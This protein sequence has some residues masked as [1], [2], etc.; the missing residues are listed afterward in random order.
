MNT[1]YDSQAAAAADRVAAAA[2]TELL[3]TECA[4]RIGGSGYH[5]VVV[6]APAGAGKSYFIGSVIDAITQNSRRGPIAAIGTPTNAQAQTLVATLARRLPT[7]DFAYVPKKGLS[8]P[9]A[10][11]TLG[12]VH[13][14][15]AADAHAYPVTI[16]TLD[17]LGDANSRGNLQR[18]RYLLIDEAYQAH[19][20]HYFGVAGLAERHLLVGDPGQLD[21]FTTMEDADRWRG[22]DEDPTQTAVGVLLR[23]HPQLKPLAMPITRRLPASALEIARSFYPGHSFT[24]WTRPDT[25]RMRLSTLAGPA[26]AGDLSSR[27]TQALD[28]TWDLAARTGWGYVRLPETPVLTADPLTIDVISGLLERGQT[29]GI[30][31]SSEATDGEWT[32]LRHG[33]IAVAVSHNDQ[34]DLLTATLSNHGIEGVVVDTANK[35]QGLEFDLLVA[36]HPLAGLPEADGFHLDPGRLCVMLTRHRHACIVVGRASDAALVGDLPP[37]S[38]AWLGYDID[39]EVDGW[40]AQQ[41]VFNQLE[42]HAVDLLGV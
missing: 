17:K 39:P 1:Y 9:P 6:K 37:A 31:L 35:L 21:P 18:Y 4:I 42:P 16:G 32:P 2:I 38:D 24:S 13:T 10:D 14:V 33:R 30:E 29:R 34:K 12:N 8:L 5:V 19:S 28:H 36:W 15:A 3:G 40:F 11:A 25:R 22:L 26:R 20:G 27:S 23:H 41:L 7:I